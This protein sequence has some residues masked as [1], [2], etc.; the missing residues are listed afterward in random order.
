M[1]RTELCGMLSGNFLLSWQQTISQYALCRVIPPTTNWPN[2][3]KSTSIYHHIY[4]STMKH[5][6]KK[7]PKIWKILLST[8]TIFSSSI[9][10]KWL[11]YYLKKNL[12]DLTFSV[13]FRILCKHQFPLNFWKAKF[14]MVYLKN[15]FSKGMQYI[16]NKSII[17]E[18][19]LFEQLTWEF[20][21]TLSKKMQLQLDCC[22]FMYTNGL[23]QIYKNTYICTCLPASTY[24]NDW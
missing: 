10:L 1:P 7:H 20:Q 5:C 2:F 23:K 9:R 4:K 24:T 12:L 17:L 13:F 14:I 11:I 3:M 16:Y 21:P 15:W 18:I 6:Q 8:H 19:V 22:N